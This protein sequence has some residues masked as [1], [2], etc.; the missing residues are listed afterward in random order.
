M[1]EAYDRYSNVSILIHWTV[2]VLVI[3]NIVIA[4]TMPND[5]DLFPWYKSINIAV[6]LLTI[7]WIG[8]RLAHPWPRFPDSVPKWERIF[9]RSV[10]FGFYFLLLAIPLIGW[11]TM[12]AGGGT[13]KIFGSIQ[14]FDLPIGK[15]A[16]LRDWLAT[17]HEA[18]V[19]LLLLLIVI[20]ACGALKHQFFDEDVVFHRMLPSLRQ[21]HLDDEI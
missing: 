13:G 16:E 20:H 14:W 3:A 10:Y 2:A 4:V 6:L 15:S 1:R 5:R 17:V 18:A 7:L 21:S 12:S 9:A 11:A 19:Y 8:W